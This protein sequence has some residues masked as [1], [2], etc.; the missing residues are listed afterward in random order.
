MR[1]DADRRLLP[2]F[3]RAVLRLVVVM[4]DGEGGERFPELAADVVADADRDFFELVEHVQLRQRDRVE[5]VEHCGRAKYGQVEP[6]G[7][8]RTAGH[9]A[10]LVAARA[11]VLAVLVVQLRW[12]RAAADA[13]RVRLRH[14]D[15]TVD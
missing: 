11:K 15:D 7:G 2:A 9:G 1:G 6:A 10:E 14:A 4:R 12:E 5:A 3:E 13:R 8:P